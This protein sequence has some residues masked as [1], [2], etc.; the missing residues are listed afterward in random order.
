MHLSTTVS[1]LTCGKHRGD[2][3]SS[4]Q[5]ASGNGVTPDD[6]VPQDIHNETTR[7]LLAPIATDPPVGIAD[8]ADALN[9]AAM[10]LRGLRES[11]GQRLEVLGG[12]KHWTTTALLRV[13]QLAGKAQPEYPE[14]LALI[15]RYTNSAL[16]DVEALINEARTGGKLALDGHAR[17]NLERAKGLADDIERRA[18][19]GLKPW[20]GR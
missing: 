14:F 20:A 16:A 9:K 3:S 11:V 1:Q 13:E 6:G 12:T 19:E 18:L 10:L 17:Y 8:V 5:P 15:V 7:P 4:R 2:F